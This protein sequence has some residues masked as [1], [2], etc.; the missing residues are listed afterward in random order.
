MLIFR[1]LDTSSRKFNAYG[2]S[3]ILSDTVGFV[4]SLPHHLIKAF[5]TTLD[6]VKNADLLLNIIDITNSV[7]N[8]CLVLI[9]EIGAGTDPDEGSALARAIIEHLLDRRSYGIITTHYSALKEFAYAD[10]R[11]MNAGMEFDP[12]TFAPLYK[13]N[14]ANVR[15]G[16]LLVKIMF[17]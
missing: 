2:K 14:I 12:Q 17:H 6:E 4:S 9:D 10:S 8:N 11:I 13:I 7:D 5:K 16:F 15:D 1:E 3:F